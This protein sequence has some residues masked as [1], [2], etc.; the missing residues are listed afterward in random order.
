MQ[1]A[2]LTPGRPTQIPFLLTTSGEVEEPNFFDMNERRV[3]VEER[4]RAVYLLTQWPLRE[5]LYNKGTCDII[6]SPWR[7]DTSA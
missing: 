1:T 7:G 4:G 5:Q 6:T 2:S 3:E